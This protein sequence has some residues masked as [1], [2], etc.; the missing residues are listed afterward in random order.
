MYGIKLSHLKVAA[1]RQSFS[2]INSPHSETP[3]RTYSRGAMLPLWAHLCMLLHSGRFY[4]LDSLLKKNN[5]LYI[6]LI[7]IWSKAG[8]WGLAPEKF[9]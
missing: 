2:C 7:V 3:A 5:V 4:L 6:G 8:V 9:S 1:S